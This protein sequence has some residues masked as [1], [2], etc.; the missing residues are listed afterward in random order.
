GAG[1]PT[2]SPDRRSGGSDQRGASERSGTGDERG[3]TSETERGRSDQDRTRTGQDQRGSD[4]RGSAKSA[5]LTTEQ[6]TRIR[7]TIVKEG[8]APRVN[9]V[10]FSLSIGTAVP[11][12]VRLARVPSTVVEIYPAWRAYEYFMVGDQIVIVDPN[13]MHIVAVLPA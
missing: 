13:T 10:N 1:A 11:R 7:Q 3:R 2:T 12:S 4:Q 5:D 8:N 6:R 9:N